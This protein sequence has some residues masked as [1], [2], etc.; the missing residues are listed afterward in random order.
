MYSGH[1]LSGNKPKEKATIT[2]VF[3]L[4]C[5]SCLL[6]PNSL[7]LLQ[8]IAKY[9]LVLMF[10][11]PL[12]LCFCWSAF[13]FSFPFSFFFFKAILL[14][15]SI[16]SH[17][18]TGWVRLEGTTLNPVSVPTYTFWIGQNWFL[19]YRDAME[20]GNEPVAESCDV[21]RQSAAGF[22]LAETFTTAE[23]LDVSNSL[24]EIAKKQKNNH[25]TSS[26]ELFK[27]N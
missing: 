10:D 22:L 13:S 26:L 24:K 8:T 19:I 1:Y 20:N 9:S 18:L 15:A 16:T 7:P 6:P 21:W 23:L 12:S 11:F 4:R 17:R 3:S 2:R 14:L 27:Q 5:S 25:T